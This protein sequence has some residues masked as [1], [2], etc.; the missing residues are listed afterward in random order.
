[1]RTAI[2]RDVNAFAGAKIGNFF[3]R[4]VWVNFDLVHGRNYF[5]SGKEL[6]ESFQREVGYS[7]ARRDQAPQSKPEVKTNPIDL[8]LP[9]K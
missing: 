7:V 4:K 8:T 1:M 6:R 2:R 5:G 9:V 3:V